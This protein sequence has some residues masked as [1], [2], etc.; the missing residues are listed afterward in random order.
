MIKRRKRE[1]PY[2]PASL[3]QKN[4]NGSRTIIPAKIDDMM[5]CLLFFTLFLPI[6]CHL[7]ERENKKSDDAKKQ[8]I[9][10]SDIPLNFCVD[11]LESPYF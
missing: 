5:V 6:L 2:N 3:S 1:F 11:K 4:G 7:V 9:G 10:T 8:G